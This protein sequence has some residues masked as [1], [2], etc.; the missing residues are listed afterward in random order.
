MFSYLEIA[1]H[2]F[3]NS[4]L[5]FLVDSFM[6]AHLVDVLPWGRIRTEE[7]FLVWICMIGDHPKYTR[8]VRMM[9]GEFPHWNYHA[10]R[11][12]V[13]WTLSY[14]GLVNVKK[15]DCDFA[16]R[17]NES[18]LLRPEDVADPQLYLN[19]QIVEDARWPGNHY[20]IVEKPVRHNSFQ[21]FWV[22]PAGCFESHLSL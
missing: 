13:T 1:L 22:G 14:K 4:P 11:W 9:L 6:V 18:E 8:R 15:H 7:M 2:L 20:V 21:S 10:L 3:D 16:Y 19:N 5:G 17:H 12:N